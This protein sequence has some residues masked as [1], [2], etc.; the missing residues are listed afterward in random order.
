MQKI[1]FHTL[2]CKVN[3]V[4]TETIKE[5]FINRGFSIVNFNELADVYII[6]TCTVTHVS[7][8][9]SRAMI[10]RAIRTNPEAV[11]VAIGCTAQVNAEEL[12][13]IEGLDLIIGNKS[14]ENIVEIIEELELLENKIINTS[15][16]D[17][18]KPNK[19]IYN[20]THDRTR[21]FI[22]IQDGCESFCSYCIVPYARGPIRSKAPEDVLE[23][24][25]NMVN[26]GYKEIVLTGIHTGF[27]GAD[28]IDWNLVKL[29]NEIT[30]SIKGDY[31]IRLSSIEP[32]EVNNKLI[33]LVAKNDKICNHFHIPLQSGSNRILKSMNRKYTRES[34]AK[35]IKEINDVI[36]DAGI[37]TDVMVGFPGENEEDY[38]L[39]YELIKTLPFLDLHVFKYSKRPGTPAYDL[40]P[41]VSNDDKQ[42]RSKELLSL[43]EKKRF[44][45]I[46]ERLGKEIKVLVEKKETSQLFRGTSENY[47]EVLFSCEKNL[48]KKFANIVL[49]GIKEKFALGQLI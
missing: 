3:Q 32:L 38:A 10:R 27:Y 33:Q 28:L 45:F 5:N 2:G 48:E 41:Q 16:E 22:K 36:P 37:T 21:A 34:Y 7:D 40:T 1:A 31:R 43:A 49:T 4:E 39:T 24:V 44:N 11:V 35:L 47:I 9:K 8:R 6:N 42:K 19:V 29:L 26:I 17:N 14:K 30:N 12:S 46:N 25:S 13:K 23:E 15:F 18:D 20:T